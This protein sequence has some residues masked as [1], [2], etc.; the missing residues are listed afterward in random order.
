MV[1][2]EREQAMLNGEMGPGFARAMRVLVGIGKAFG[3][4]RMVPITRGHISLSNQEG[5]LWFC[6]KLLEEG[7]Y[8]QVPPSVNPAYD[9]EYFK[10]VSNLD[11]ENERTLKSTIDVYRKLG[12]IL[13]FD[14]T[15]FFENNVARFGEITSFSASGGAVYVNSV[16]GART[17]RE[18]AQ[19]AMCAAI[20][21]VTPE[22]GL[23]LDENRAGDV[24]IQVEADIQT[25]YDCELLG[26]ITPKKMGQTYHCPVFNG[27]SPRT[28]AEQLMNMGVQLNIHGIVPM[29]HV[30]GVT[31]EAADL[32]AA[33]R[34]KKDYPV[35]TIT[36]EDLAEARAEISSGTG[37]ADFCILG[38]P[39]L[40]INQVGSIAKMLEGQQLVGQLYIFTSTSTKELARRMGYLDVIHKAGGEIVIN[41]CVDQPCWSHLHG[42][43][44]V[45]ESP[46][47][48]YYT[49]RWNMEFTVKSIPACIQSVLKGE[50]V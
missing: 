19:S 2:T 3:A 11:A 10:T 4:E 48:A 18:A 21:G 8:C 37:K 39:H 5:D 12:A 50:I 32:N 38:C 36:N 26:Y 28:T 6:S 44:G 15:P 24:L 7:A 13:T 20:T 35:V 16:L 27:L 45:T 34:G 23:L 22:Y 46:K 30:V 14:C 1:L 47:C 40:T 42:K 43:S 17:N 41:S 9:Y 25:E 29:F 33:F 31:P 49:K